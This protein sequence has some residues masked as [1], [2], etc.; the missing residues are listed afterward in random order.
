MHRMCRV[1]YT[2]DILDSRNGT[3]FPRVQSEV[4]MATPSHTIIILQLCH[5]GDP[6]S[7]DLLTYE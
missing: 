2:W 5:G 1:R 3:H 7:A 6:Y 4:D